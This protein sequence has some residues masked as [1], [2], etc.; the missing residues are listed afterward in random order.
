[1]LSSVM[2]WRKLLFDGAIIAKAPQD[3]FL[4]FSLLFAYFSLSLWHKQKHKGG[5]ARPRYGKALVYAALTP[6]AVPAL[7][8][9]LGSPQSLVDVAPTL[10][11]GWSRQ[12]PSHG[13][14]A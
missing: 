13:T 9:T 2:E 8:K 4:N 3:N 1:M 12:T 5:S 14:T 10:S 11:Q 7:A 6:T